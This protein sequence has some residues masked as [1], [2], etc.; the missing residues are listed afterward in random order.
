MYN[1]KNIYWKSELFYILKEDFKYASNI[2]NS[3]TGE[4]GLWDKYMVYSFS[5]GTKVRGKK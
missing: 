4:H 2:I 5:D 3:L 1:R